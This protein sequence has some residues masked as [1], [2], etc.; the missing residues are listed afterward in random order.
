MWDGNSCP[1]IE[2]PQKLTWLL[3]HGSFQRL[4]KDSGQDRWVQSIL[5]LSIPLVLPEFPQYNMYS[6]QDKTHS[7][8]NSK[9]PKTSNM[10]YH[11]ITPEILDTLI[12]S[13]VLVP[14]EKHARP[15]DLFLAFLAQRKFNHPNSSDSATLIKSYS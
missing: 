7:T 9:S 8:F 3:Q 4:D 2:S 5:L 15:L 10:S 14:K 6:S 1:T 11:T 12:I 13:L